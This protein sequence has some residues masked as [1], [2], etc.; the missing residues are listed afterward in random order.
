MKITK[1]EVFSIPN[2][3]G[4]F[5]ILLV[6]VFAWIYCTADSSSDYYAA[7][8]V[9]GVSGITDLLDGKIARKFDMITELGKFIDP[10]ADKL[11][12]GVLILCMTTR[13]S[14]MWLLVGIFIV[15]EGF[16]IVAGAVLLHTKGRKLDGA[17]WYGKVC[18]ALLYVIMFILLLFPNIPTAAVNT[19]ILFSA[20]LM[21][22]TLALYIP[23]FYKMGKET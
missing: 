14:L 20:A 13:W 16:M 15:K 23:V 5:R 7:A 22:V 1:K 9:A 18:T 3:L 2:I 12:Q 21:A 19:F 17:K 8:I 6:P 4:Y 11:T 10:F